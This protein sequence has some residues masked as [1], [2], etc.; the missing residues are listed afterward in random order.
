MN[1]NAQEIKDALYDYNNNEFWID[2]TDIG[3]V[4][5]IRLQ[6][7]LKLELNDESYEDN[8]ELELIKNDSL[9][10]IDDLHIYEYAK[11]VFNFLKTLNLDYRL[12]FHIYSFSS[13]LTWI[14]SQNEWDYIDGKITYR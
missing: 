10:R 6:Y 5:P 1:I 2:A 12:S 8:I 7:W 9:D 3:N 4:F 11:D 13:E 14:N